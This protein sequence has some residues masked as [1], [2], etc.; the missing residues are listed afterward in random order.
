MRNNLTLPSNWVLAPPHSKEPTADIFELKTASCGKIY[1]EN[2][3]EE[4]DTLKKDITRMQECLK[5]GFGSLHLHIGRK[6]KT[7]KDNKLLVD[8]RYFGALI[9]VYE[10]MWCVLAGLSY[11][12]PPKGRVF[13][14][15]G[16]DYMQTGNFPRS[17]LF[18]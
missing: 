13:I 11:A 1:H 7:T 9:K 10:A 14:T 4:W 12:A 8:K 3:E 18:F 16:I 15:Y 6:S 2:R 5:G 17:I